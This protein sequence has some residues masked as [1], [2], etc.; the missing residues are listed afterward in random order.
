MK[1]T[2]RERWPA[3]RRRRLHIHITIIKQH[4]VDGPA[5]SAAM[6]RCTTQVPHIHTQWRAHVRVTLAGGASAPNWPERITFS[7]NLCTQFASFVGRPVGPSDRSQLMPKFWSARDTV[8]QVPVGG[9]GTKPGELYA[10]RV[11]LIWQMK[12]TR[13]ANFPANPFA[14]CMCLCECECVWYAICA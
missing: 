12:F 13:A 3:K 7:I 5:S 9:G 8:G 4:R 1:C 11:V 6:R 10:A 14:M 2:L